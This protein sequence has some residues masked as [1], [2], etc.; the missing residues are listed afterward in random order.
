MVK[1]CNIIIYPEL[2]VSDTNIY[3]YTHFREK[4]GHKII[5]PANIDGHIVRHVIIVRLG[6]KQMNDQKLVK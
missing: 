1:E 4:L 5:G 2:D 6:L 3:I